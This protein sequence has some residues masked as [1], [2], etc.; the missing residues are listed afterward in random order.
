MAYT[1]INKSTVYFNNK[2]YTGNAGTQ[3]ITGVGFQPDMT[4]I[5]RRGSAEDHALF[6]AVRGATKRITPSRDYTEATQT[7]SLTSFNSD[8]F[9][10][11]NGDSVNGSDNYASWNWKANGAGSANTDGTISS[12]VSANTTSGFS[13]VSWNGNSGTVG[14]GLGAKPAMII[15]KSRQTANNWVVMHQGLTGGMDTNVVVLNDTGAEGGGGA[16][17]AEP[18]SSVFT[19]TSGLAAND[20]NIAYCFAEK[21]GYSKFG[22]YI[23]N[24]NNDGPFV[25]TG[26]KPSFVMT[27][28]KDGASGRGML[29]NK[30]PGYNVTHQY[31]LANDAQAEQNDGSWSMDLLSNGWK[32]RYNNG[33]FNANGGTYIYVAFGQSIVGS[34]N[35]P[36]TAR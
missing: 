26:F 22:T 10:L 20:N 16:G 2:I 31:L 1:T 21:Q 15:V 19:I 9:S 35:I 28:R 25:Y 17:M 5:K 24:G 23:G 34:N 14:H 8:G 32:A 7:G 3:S 11:G 4:W 18:T 33:N 13:V 36:A 29:D 12:T 27:I 30:R 6:D